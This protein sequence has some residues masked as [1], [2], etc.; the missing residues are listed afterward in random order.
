MASTRVDLEA[1]LAEVRTSLATITG[2]PQVVIRATLPANA[3]YPQSASHLIVDL[4][5]TAP[6]NTMDGSV[7]EDLALQIGAW[8]NDSLVT[9]IALADA[10][11]VKLEA[12]GY[13]RTGGVQLVVEDAYHGVLITYTLTAAF[14][15]LT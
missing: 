8:A 6:T 9:A 7:I 4:I 11:R 12:L 14:A 2:T 3:A 13:D 5:P 10:A 15:A 1:H